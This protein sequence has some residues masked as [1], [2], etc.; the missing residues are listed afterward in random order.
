MNQTHNGDDDFTPTKVTT[1]P[2]NTGIT[3]VD[4]V[5]GEKIELE[6]LRM[7][8]H[9]CEIIS[10]NPMK[11]SNDTVAVHVSSLFKGYQY[12]NGKLPRPSTRA[13]ATR[14]EATDL[15]NPELLST[16]LPQDMRP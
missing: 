3:V 13:N 16:H 6:Y 5:T 9:P 10:E 12:R 15:F 7:R 8:L 2:H 11:Y 4:P 14:I 1:I